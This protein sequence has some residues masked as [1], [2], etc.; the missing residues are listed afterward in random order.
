MG[1]GFVNTPANFEDILDNTFDSLRGYGVTTAG[2]PATTTSYTNNTGHRLVITF[3]TATGATYTITD[4][5]GV[6][7]PAITATVGGTAELLGGEII[8]PTYTTLTWRF[9]AR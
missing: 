2:V 6:T 7:G 8:T 4:L 3:L 9:Y 1:T 5:N